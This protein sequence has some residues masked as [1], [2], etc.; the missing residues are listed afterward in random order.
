M[1][2]KRRCDSAELGSGASFAIPLSDSIAPPQ[3]SFGPV[4]TTLIVIDH[5]PLYLGVNP[6]SKSPAV[7]TSRRSV[8]E[9]EIR[10]LLLY[11]VELGS[12]K[13]IHWG[14]HGKWCR[15]E[16]SWGG[17][18]RSLSSPLAVMVMLSSRHER[19]HQN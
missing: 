14:H 5:L 17:A 9:K 13:D 18:S 16:S 2:Q 7:R 12:P 11:C 4:L 10:C 6:S 19:S 1:R 15:T 8:N 3:S